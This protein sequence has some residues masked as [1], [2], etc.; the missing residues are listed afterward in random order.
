MTLPAPAG[1]PPRRDRPIRC[2]VP[3][4]GRAARAAAVLATGAL[5]AACTGSGD[6]EETRLISGYAGLAAADE[7]RAATVGREILANNGTAADAAAAM[8]FTMTVTLPSRVGLG[9]GGVCV[10]SD[11]AEQNVEAIS[12]LPRRAA[13]GG[14]V[15]GLA[16]GLALLH[17]RHGARDWRQ[18]V[19]PAERL[20]RFGHL[21]S[22]AFKRDLDAGAGRLHGAARDRF[23]GDDGTPPAVGQ[24]IRHPA[25]SAVLA[26]IRQQGAGYLYTGQFA[27]RLAQAARD[28]GQP[29]SES[30]LNGYR[31]RAQSTLT[32]PYGD[33]QLH[34]PP[35]PAMSGLLAGQTWGMLRAGGDNAPALSGDSAHLL[36][37]AWKRSLSRTGRWLST[38][39]AERADPQSLLSENS[40]TPSFNSID[41]GAATPAASLTP[42][43]PRLSGDVPTAGLTAVD[44]FG[45]MVACGFTMNGLFGSGADTIGTGVLLANPSAETA[46]GADL[47]PG[48]IANQFTGRGYLAVSGS[49][50]AAGVL[51]A[52]EL[53]R[54]LDSAGAGQPDLQGF[55]GL[56]RLYH[57]GQPDRLQVEPGLPEDV[58]QRLSTMGHALVKRPG[59]G[60]LTA[61]YC[62]GGADSDGSDCAAAVDPRGSGLAV[63]A[64]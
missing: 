58:T 19:S 16:R 25:L 53:V 8:A 52:A 38:A 32:V 27:E 18:V 39:E 59:L 44:R 41:P 21:T 7:P 34:L 36:A 54:K 11:R 10:V 30:A 43:P 61:I 28:V 55:L 29:F 62:Q 33:H 15:P 5:A 26:G 64:Q 3:K 48:V 6:I 50:G 60:R 63:R 42:P 13:Q 31:A 51:N 14:V 4:L 9:G 47:L 2:L 37:E 12:F 56:P 24:R 17:A 35:P 49:D 45:N 20:A 22:R 40:L 46:A 1:A 23:L 57:P